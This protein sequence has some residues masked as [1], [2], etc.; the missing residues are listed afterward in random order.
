MASKGGLTSDS[1]GNPREVLERVMGCLGTQE[2]RLRFLDLCRDYYGQRVV[3]GP[4]R[5]ECH[6]LIME[7]YVRLRLQAAANE[8]PLLSREEVGQAIMDYF[9]S[10]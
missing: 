9:R 4:R 1:A 3:G 2:A 10:A 6:N 8:V 5:A 7:T